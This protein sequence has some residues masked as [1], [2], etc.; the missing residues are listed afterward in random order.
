MDEGVE[1][2]MD[3][4]LKGWME[5]GVKGWVDGRGEDVDQKPGR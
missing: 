1:D 4:R 2:W 5:D 3:E